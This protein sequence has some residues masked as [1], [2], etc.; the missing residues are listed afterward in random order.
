MKVRFQD[1]FLHI[2]AVGTLLLALIVGGLAGLFYTFVFGI[3]VA[4]LRLN[5]E[6]KE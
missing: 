6:E 5:A 2:S 4:Q 3:C 1:T